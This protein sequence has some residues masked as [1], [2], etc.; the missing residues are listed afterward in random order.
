MK[1]ALVGYG[2][3][4]KEIERLA[5]EAGHEVL[6]KA[7]SSNLLIDNLEALQNI[8]VAIE[9]STPE[10]AY[11][12]ICLLLSS[13]VPVVCGTTAWLD[14]RA[15][16]EAMCQKEESAFFYASNFSLGVNLF[17]KLNQ[18]LA[19]LMN[20]FQDSYKVSLKEI[21]HTTKLDAPSG[22]GISLAE[23]LIKIFPNKT[24]WSDSDA[25]DPNILL[26]SERLPN[27]PGTHDVKYASEEDS[28]T[29]T[30]VAHSRAGFAKGA[31]LAA[32]WIVG[33]KGVFGMNDLLNL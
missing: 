9:F 14:R 28:I 5:L 13:K 21:H 16:V 3:M 10:T 20:Q 12:N 30:H 31:L 25:A 26:E 24:N 23:D 4:G 17:F 19:S 29:I 22:T 18:Q 27:V 15:E 6:L 32:Q 8:D 33:K 7:G 1:I 11:E 2:K